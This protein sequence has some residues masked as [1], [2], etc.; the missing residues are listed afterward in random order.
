MLSGIIYTDEW[1]M[2]HTKP[3]RGRTPNKCP[4]LPGAGTRCFNDPE[5]RIGKEAS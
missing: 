3:L 1:L 2:G 4:P 5:T